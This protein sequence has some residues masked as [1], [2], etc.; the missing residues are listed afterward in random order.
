MVRVSRVEHWKESGV[1]Q[2]GFW[3]HQEDTSRDQPGR[4]HSLRN[5]IRRSLSAAF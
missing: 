4:M 3:L 5:S 2:E 1:A